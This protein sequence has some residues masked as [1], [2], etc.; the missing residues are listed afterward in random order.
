MSYIVSE[1]INVL[2]L[3]AHF[4]VHLNLHV[5]LHVTKPFYVINVGNDLANF[6]LAD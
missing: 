6:M 3:S 2:G 5:K 4:Y 1:S